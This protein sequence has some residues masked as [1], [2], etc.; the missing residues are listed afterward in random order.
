MVLECSYFLRF[1]SL[2][3]LIG[4]EGCS[5]SFH[6]STN[7]FHAQWSS[8][9]RRK[10]IV[11]SWSRD[12][13][14]T[15]SYHVITRMI[16]SHDPNTWLTN[17]ILTSSHHWFHHLRQYSYIITT[18][19]SFICHTTTTSFYHHGTY[20]SSSKNLVW[21]LNRMLWRSTRKTTSRSM[22]VLESSDGSSIKEKCPRLL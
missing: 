18:S 22:P 11:M 3:P 20:R 6:S 13:P 15:W 12:L 7:D 8:C 10:A 1:S 9:L 21:T 2:V 19:G 16:Y 14:I 17:F 5:P 4:L